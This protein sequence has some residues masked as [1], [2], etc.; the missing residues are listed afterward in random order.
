MR[1]SIF[2]H[3]EFFLKKIFRYGG[4]LAGEFDYALKEDG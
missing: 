2:L 1:I 4:F 3:Q